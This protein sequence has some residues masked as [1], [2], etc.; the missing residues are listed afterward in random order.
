MSYT[1]THTHVGLCFRSTH[2]NIFIDHYTNKATKARSSGYLIYGTESLV[3]KSRLPPREA[4]IL[5]FARVNPHLISGC[6]VIIDVVNAVKK[7]E[8]V[9]KLWLRRLLMLNSHSVIAPLF[10]ELAVMPIRCRRIL[11]TLRY[12][13]YLLKLPATHYA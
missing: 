2:K 4:R 6:E 1:P 8:K 3:R 13:A 12:L 11:L 9:Q 7:L 5:Y 10:T